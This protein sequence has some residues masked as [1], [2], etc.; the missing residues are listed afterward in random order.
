M[1]IDIKILNKYL[2]TKFKNTSKKSS[3]VIKLSSFQS[4]KDGSYVNQ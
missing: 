2:E 4:C 3:T 1:S